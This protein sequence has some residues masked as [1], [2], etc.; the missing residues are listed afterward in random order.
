MMPTCAEGVA[1]FTAAVSFVFLLFPSIS[2]RGRVR[3]GPLWV[4]GDEEEENTYTGHRV[5]QARAL[6]AFH[7]SA[8][9]SD[10]RS[11]SC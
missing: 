2:R 7:W 10:C 8:L 1:P 9:K 11:V 5:G 6:T 4:G 3:G